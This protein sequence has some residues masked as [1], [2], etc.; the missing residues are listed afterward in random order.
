MLICI[1]KGCTDNFPLSIHADKIEQTDEFKAEEFNPDFVRSLVDRIDYPALIR[2]LG[3]L[4]LEHLLP[5]TAS[6]VDLNNDDVARELHRLLLD[7]HLSEGFLCCEKCGR[8][9]PVNQGIPNMLL[10]EDEV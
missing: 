8:K 6:D 2:A 5:P 3:Q 1:V 9:Y 4:K 10:R 7:I